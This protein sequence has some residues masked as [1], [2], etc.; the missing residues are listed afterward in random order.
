MSFTINVIDPSGT[1]KNQ[2][3]VSVLAH[4]VVQDL[5]GEMSYFVIMSTGAK[6]VSGHAIAQNTIMGLT[7]GAGGTGLDRNG[8]SL[9]GGKYANLTT[10][11]NDYVAMMVEGNKDEPWTEMAFS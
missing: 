11:I 3:S 1:K 2:I 10:A 8:S 9:S 7:D 5:T 4:P 6:D